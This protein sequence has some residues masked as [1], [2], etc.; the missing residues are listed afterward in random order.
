MP[1]RCFF[2]PTGFPDMPAS[3]A[4]QPNA[5]MLC[6]PLPQFHANQYDRLVEG[7][8]YDRVSLKLVDTQEKLWQVRR[9]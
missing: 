7:E 2:E 3:C 1:T 4:P 9:C 8:G 5:P 6:V